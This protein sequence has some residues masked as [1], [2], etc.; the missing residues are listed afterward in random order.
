MRRVLRG[1]V[2]AACVALAAWPLL[3]HA[4]PRP[5]VSFSSPREGSTVTGPKVSV[6]VTVANFT[7]VDAGTAVKAGEGHVHLYVDREPLATGSVIPT[8]QAG[9]IHLGKAPYDTR[10]VDLQPGRHT[11]H[12]Q[13]ADASHKALDVPTARVRFTVSAPGAGTGPS[14]PADTGDGSLADA[15][16]G[17]LPVLL[18]AGLAAAVL[19]VRASR[20]V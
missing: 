2:V 5:T 11:V 18:V 8:D 14:R 10:E 1:S 3:V 12:A 17:V 4:Q 13:L 16:S 19:L 7:T 15:G 6:K 20:R 9:I